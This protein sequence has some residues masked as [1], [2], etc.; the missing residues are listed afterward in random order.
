MPKLNRLTTQPPPTPL[1]ML[2][3]QSFDSTNW[4]DKKYYLWLLS[5]GIPLLGVG[6]LIAY[7][8]SPKKLRALTWIGLGLVHGIIPLLDKLLGE[9][10][11]NP[12]EAVIAELEKNPYYSTLVKAYI[13]TQFLGNFFGMYLATR[14]STPWLDKIAIMSTVGVLNGVAFNTSHE[15]SHKHGALDKFLSKLTIAPTGY[16]HFQVEHPFGHHKRVAT[17]EDPASS[18]MGESY[19]KFLP[20]SVIGGFKSAIDIETKRLKRKG[21]G[22]FTLENELLQGWA[23]SAGFVGLSAAMFGKK[24]LPMLAGQAVYAVSL[25]EIINYVEHYG[26]MRAKDSNGKYV[27]TLPEHSWNSNHIMTNLILYQLQ[28]HSDHHAFP[29]RSFQALRHFDNTPQL[30]S[31]YASMLL[32]AYIPKLWYKLM[33]PRVVAHYK[34]DLTKANIEPAKREALMQKYAQQA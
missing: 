1:S 21:K 7:K 8:A 24:V 11:S 9:D 33:D 27:R 4:Q 31:G 17:P 15:L 3:P 22:F 12:P 34:G 30:P 29:T 16:T 6:A 10:L 26:L 19:W 32:P 14:K 2:K 20:R 25:F 13:P 18:K 28:R 23:L 5:P